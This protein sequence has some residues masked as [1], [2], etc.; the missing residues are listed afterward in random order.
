MKIE[1]RNEMFIKERDLYKI[2]YYNSE[3]Q[4]KYEVLKKIETYGIDYF[5][6][7]EY[8]FY[9]EENYLD[10][11]NIINKTPQLIDNNEEIVPIENFY[12][13]EILEGYFRIQNE[14]FNLELNQGCISLIHYTDKPNN[15]IEEIDEYI[16]KMIIDNQEKSRGESRTLY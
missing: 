8:G 11:V 3:T 15:K 12:D 13:E 10:I 1:K 6:P 5:F 9:G 14:K 4:K 7:V 16:I 2:E